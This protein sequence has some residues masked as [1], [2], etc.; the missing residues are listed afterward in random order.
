MGMIGVPATNTTTFMAY[1]LD[2]NWQS[3]GISI[4]P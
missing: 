1:A 3:S 4:L 2:N